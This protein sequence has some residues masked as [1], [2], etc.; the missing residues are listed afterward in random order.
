M[1]L[2][3]KLQNY[4]LNSSQ[5]LL[6][7]TKYPIQVGKREFVIDLLFYN[8]KLHCYFVAELKTVEFEPEFL[9]ISS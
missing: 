1:F 3:N 7:G 5:V 6:Y 4:Y 2:S 8:V 9:F